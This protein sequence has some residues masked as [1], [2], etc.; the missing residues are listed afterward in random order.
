MRK[1]GQVHNSYKV[2]AS[3][4]TMVTLA[5]PALASNEEQTRYVVKLIEEHTADFSKGIQLLMFS[6]VLDNPEME[7]EIE[8]I[9]RIIVPHSF[10][11]FFHAPISPHHYDSRLNLAC[12]ESVA[13]Y[14]HL[15][16]LVE[17][18][19]GEAMIIH[20]N[21]TYGPDQW[22]IPQ[23]DRE[24]VYEKVLLKIH[25][26]IEAI[27]KQSP[28]PILLE[29]LPLPLYGDSTAEPTRIP[30]DPFLGTIKQIEEFYLGADARLQFCFDTS[31]FGILSRQVNRLAKKYGA[32][33]TAEQI[34]H[35]GLK[36]YAQDVQLQ[37][38]LMQMYAALKELLD[39]RISCVQ[40]AD[41]Q[42]EWRCAHG[43][44]SGSIFHEGYIVGK[45][46]LGQELLD[47]TVA[48]ARE[49][50]HGFISVDVNVQDFLQRDEQIE[51]LQAVVAALKKA[52][53][54]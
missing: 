11:K 46:D 37:P 33:I 1:S 28:V 53:V 22:R 10:R 41:Y 3:L 9:S 2:L 36:I 32:K 48:Y 31:H 47:F 12:E 43:L 29:N 34:N 39:T 25:H 38:A 52:K 27:I 14:V 30:F 23:S 19:G 7:R 6:Q 45:G 26:N 17:R 18:C 16:K 20:T 42:G 35:E 49:Y 13:V 5:L 8:R 50:P 51:S 24:V 54:H 4:T 40:L 15:A 21:C 44:D